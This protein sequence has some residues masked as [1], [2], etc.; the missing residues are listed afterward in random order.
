MHTFCVL[1]ITAMDVLL[2][3]GPQTYNNTVYRAFCARSNVFSILSEKILFKANYV[4]VHTKDLRLILVEVY[5]SF[6]DL[7]PEIKQKYLRKDI[8]NI[9][10]EKRLHLFQHDVHLCSP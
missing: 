3:A 5:K 7:S 9:S 4:P 10:E 2:Q 8:R 6:H 1:L